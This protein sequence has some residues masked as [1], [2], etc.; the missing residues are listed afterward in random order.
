MDANASVD[1]RCKHHHEAKDGSQFFLPEEFE[2][3]EEGTAAAAPV[4]C[5]YDSMNGYRDPRLT[6]SLR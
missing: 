3:V 5:G 2:L 4:A 1:H 6:H